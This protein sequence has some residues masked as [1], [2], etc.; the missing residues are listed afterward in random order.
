MASVIHSCPQSLLALLWTSCSL[1]AE[2]HVNRGFQ[3]FVQKTINHRKISFK[4]R[5]TPVKSSPARVFHNPKADS[6]ELP[7]KSVG[8]S[9]DKVFAIGYRP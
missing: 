8:A 7:P 2:S 4:Q 3:G 6:A 1:T 5:P 9:V